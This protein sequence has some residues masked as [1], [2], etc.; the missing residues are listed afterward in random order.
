MINKKYTIKYDNNNLY[1]TTNQYCK[2][3]LLKR[4]SYEELLLEVSPHMPKRKTNLSIIKYKVIEVHNDGKTLT[5]LY[6]VTCGY[7]KCINHR[8]D[9]IIRAYNINEMMKKYNKLV[10]DFLNKDLGPN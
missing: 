3:C 10:D 7:N 4:T 9:F 1:I 8:E 5:R 2:I 6:S